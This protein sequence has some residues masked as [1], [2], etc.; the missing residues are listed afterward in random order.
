M[1]K[2]TELDL[3]C[4]YC[5]FH[6]GVCDGQSLKI[7][8]EIGIWLTHTYSS[9]RSS[10]NNEWDLPLTNN[11]SVNVGISSVNCRYAQTNSEDFW[12]EISF[13]YVFGVTDWI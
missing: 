6:L 9:L 3:C 12:N 10:L 4:Q 2:A 7:F 1:S 13:F 8:K 11:S 5:I